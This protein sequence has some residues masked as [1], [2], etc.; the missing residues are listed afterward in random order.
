MALDEEKMSSKLVLEHTSAEKPLATSQGNMQLTPDSNV[1]IG[2]GSQ[3]F[4]FEFSH[5]ATQSRVHAHALLSV[6]ATRASPGSLL[7]RSRARKP[8][9][10]CLVGT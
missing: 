9:W 2:W 4:A 7:P 3:P 10:R 6:Y 5:E 1:F 8:S